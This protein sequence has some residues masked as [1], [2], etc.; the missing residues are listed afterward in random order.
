[1]LSDFL[2]SQKINSKFRLLLALIENMLLSSAFLSGPF[3]AWA[4][5]CLNGGGTS[6]CTST[7]ST[8]ALGLEAVASPANVFFEYLSSFLPPELLHLTEH[9]DEGCVGICMIYVRPRT[10]HLP[11]WD[12]VC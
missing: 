8:T 9:L 4:P 7:P 10:K 2:C 5:K 12:V 6:A 3:P 1:M 11:K